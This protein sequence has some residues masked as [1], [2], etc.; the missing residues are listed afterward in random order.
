MFLEKILYKLVRP[1]FRKWREM[2]YGYTRLVEVLIYKEHLLHNAAQY[3]QAAPA[4]GLAPVLKSNAYGHGLLDVAR[5]FDRPA[6]RF[7]VVDGY[8]EALI[9]RNEG[10]RAEILVVGYTATE[11]I[12]GCRL[13]NV[14]FTLFDLPQ[15][16][17]L[18]QVLT[19]PRRIHL[20][21]DTGMHRQGVLL[22]EVEQAFTVIRSNENII[23]DGLCSHLADADGP[24][25]TYTM[26]QIERWNA[27]AG[28]VRRA[29]PT[30]KH[31]HLANT[32][33]TFFA[34]RIDATVMRVGLGLYGIN[35]NPRHDL[36]LKPALAV[37]SRVGAVKWIKQ[38]DKVGYNVTYQADRDMPLAIIPTGYNS[39]V[40]RRLSNTGS[41]T[42]N[43]RPCP[44]VGRVSMNI[45]TV[46]VRGVVGVRRGAT[47]TVI[48]EDPEAENAVENIARLCGTIPY[49]IL[50]NISPQLKR[51]V[52]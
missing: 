38:G 43:G 17:E 22:D 4:W 41:F 49:V 32:A 50:V 24:D 23:L 44:I 19:T 42:I 8:Y 26:Q 13:R 11:N 21:V 7:L 33:G 31:F 5:V 20:K 52:V 28:M 14:A 36:D 48:S 30:L 29:F 6:T 16:E 34:D 10:I 3:Q 27:L 1:V 35:A 2:R 15:L 46:D 39:C 9:L 45:T 40:D 25:E 18:A 12:I 51:V 37:Q 47:V